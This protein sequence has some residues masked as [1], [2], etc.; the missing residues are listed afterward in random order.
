MVI[1]LE[2]MADEL[3]SIKGEMSEVK[4]MVKDIHVLL[5]GNPIDRDAGGLL[6]E[7][8]T[9][10]VEVND[11]RDQLRKYKSYFYALVTLIGMGALKVIIEFFA[12]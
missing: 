6:S 4:V 12:K 10:K 7:I 11:I 3:E 1:T 5:A 9:M 8:R 2:S